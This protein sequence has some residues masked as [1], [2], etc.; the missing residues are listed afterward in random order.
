MHPLIPTGRRIFQGRLINAEAEVT[1][2]FDVSGSPVVGVS[3]VGVT[4]TFDPIPEPTTLFLV[5]QALAVLAGV[6]KRR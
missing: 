1:T 3:I 6:R 4:Y 5:A 2:S